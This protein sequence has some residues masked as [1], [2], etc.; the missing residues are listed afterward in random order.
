MKAPAWI[1]L[2]ALA[3]LS[4]MVVCLPQQWLPAAALAVAAFIAVTG[5]HLARLYRMFLPALP[6][7]IILSS[8]QALLQGDIMLAASSAFRMA[9]LYVSGSAVSVTTGEAELAG[10]IEGALHPVDR[11]T[12]W[13]AGRDISTMVT[14]ALAF[15][16][17]VGEEYRSI[18][19]AQEA[20]GI[21]Y[22]GP[23]KKLRGIQAIA[24]PLLYSLSRRADDI[25]LAME[26]RCYGINGH[27]NRGAS[28]NTGRSKH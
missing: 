9:L 21:R 26:A 11:L 25:A 15:I 14:L 12:G 20:R 6:F 13:R 24:V 1:K 4:V 19:M 27:K 5:A 3:T 17:M 2:L 18:K 28:I 22:G 16:P 10:A 8:L 7:I 23:L